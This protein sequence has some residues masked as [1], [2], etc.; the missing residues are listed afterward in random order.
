[1][2]KQF[3][4]RQ[5]SLR[6]PIILGLAV[7]G[8]VVLPGSAFAAGSGDTT[9]TL[10]WI[11]VLL[12]L[13]KLSSLVEKFRQ[14]AVI[15][16]LLMGVLVGNLALLGFHQLDPI[17]SDAIIAFLA[18]LGVIILLFQIGLESDT[19]TLRKVGVRALLVAIVGV[20]AP[21]AL[22]TQAVGPMLF[23]DAGFNAHLFLGATLTAT[24]V[25]VTA[26]VFKDMGTLR[27]AESQIVLGAA[28]I[29]DVIGL[30]ILAVVTAIVTTG[31][32]S[33]GAIGWITAKAFLFL[34]GALLVGQHAAPLISRQFSRINT[35]VG[36]KFSLAIS[37]CL[38]LAYLAH[39]IGLAPIIGAFAAGLILDEVAFKDYDSLEII[40]DIER[41]MKD[42]SPASQHKIREVLDHHAEHHLES[43]A[44][45]IGH[46]FIPI[47][48]VYTGMQVD[49]KT[50]F[51]LQA[52]Q[53]A[54]VVTLIAFVGK[55]VSGLVAGPVNKWIV[56]WG[57]A[58]RG[59]VG[60]IFAVVGK[61]LGVI[62]AQTFSIIIIM[63]MLTTLITPLI[64]SGL[65]RRQRRLTPDA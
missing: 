24:S 62:D 20:A 38:V 55:L 52:L 23:P 61:Q 60:L 9:R 18:E 14:P 6:S 54:L 3:F 40:P 44:G 13:A 32:V 31:E 59:E 45:P 22:G 46:L 51:D 25:G 53:I 2:L 57:M 21:F 33:L 64:L 4:S 39:L 37:F 16:E 41:A 12:I 43:L 26:R 10:L 8:L 28:V 29:D 34:A 15:G 36:M 5:H 19:R 65:I 49:L 63:V 56:G 17:K 35:G 1:M 27:M 30:I 11:A 48:F 50:L 58:P 47:F 42:A 7:L